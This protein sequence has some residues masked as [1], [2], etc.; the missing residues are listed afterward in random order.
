MRELIAAGITPE[1]YR[2]A[3]ESSFDFCT[4]TI[5]WFG[6][7]G[8]NKKA[9]TQAVASLEI[10][11]TLHY[12]CGRHWELQCEVCG[13]P[14]VQGCDGGASD[15]CSAPLCGQHSFA[16]HHPD[17]SQLAAGTSHGDEQGE[18]QEEQHA[19]QHRDPG[20]R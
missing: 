1:A 13:R 19:L 3:W 12:F 5:A 11:G 2:V 7:C 16:D 8:R 18:T 17:S 15:A 14:A 4:Y 6:Q 9:G 20:D 10:D